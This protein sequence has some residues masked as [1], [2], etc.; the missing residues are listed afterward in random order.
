MELTV[1]YLSV[2][3][4][5]F[6]VYIFYVDKHIRMQAR[7]KHDL[8]RQVLN[9]TFKDA[10]I[11]Y[12]ENINYQ[13]KMSDQG[14]QIHTSIRR[15]S[16]PTFRHL[17]H[18]SFPIFQKLYKHLKLWKHAN[19]P[20]SKPAKLI[21]SFP[22]PAASWNRRKAAKSAE[23]ATT[24]GSDFEKLEYA[25]EA[26]ILECPK[27]ELLYY[28]DVVGVVPMIPEAAAALDPQDIGNG[29]VPPE[30]GIDLALNGGSLRY[31]P[32]AVSD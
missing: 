25:K 21:S 28:T 19:N 26:K 9:L 16:Q 20:F 4:I 23:N 6:S 17:G 30:W 1:S 29:D 2:F 11:R 24:L 3:K 10:S 5:L 32:W 27:L 8:Y 12:L 13:Q 7:S 15:S 31:G 18:L 14:R 22:H